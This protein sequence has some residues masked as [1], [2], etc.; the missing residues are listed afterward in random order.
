MAKILAPLPLRKFALKSSAVR[1]A[2]E[3]DLLPE[4]Y[5]L[6]QVVENGKD[7]WMVHLKN[8]TAPV[9]PAPETLTQKMEQVVAE[10]VHEAAPTISTLLG[11]TETAK[12]EEPKT[13][14]DGVP[15][16]PLVVHDTTTEEGKA[17]FDA[18]HPVEPK[19]EPY[20]APKKER[21]VH[22]GGVTKKPT[23]ARDIGS[24]TLESPVKACWAI[25]DELKAA[26]P[27]LKRKD[28]IQAA[29]ARGIAYGTA[30]TQYQSWFAANR[31][32]EAN[33]RKAN[34]KHAGK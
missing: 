29:E 15:L 33:A 7:F 26:N 5:E 2:K 1:A 14:A 13:D 3:N 20:K 6:K 12:V 28:A 24:S 8:E 21:K 11:A 10:A 4:E 9:A 27:G 22:T 19:A 17:K 31:E 34:E 25:F 18:E 23:W 32:S 16:K 30:R